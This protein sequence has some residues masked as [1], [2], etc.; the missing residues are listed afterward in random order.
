ML[1]RQTILS[2]VLFV[3]AA[4]S[5]PTRCDA[6]PGNPPALSFTATVFGATCERANGVLAVM[7][8]GG[9]A[10]YT[11]SL[12]GGPFQTDPVF[13]GLA[14]GSYTIA[15]SDAAGA[16]VTNSYTVANTFEPPTIAATHHDPTSCSLTD[17]TITPSGTGTA[18]PF[19]FSLDNINYQPNNN[20][21]NLAAGNYTVFIEDANGCTN[22]FHLTLNAA[23]VPD[24]SF[25]VSQ[26]DCSNYGD[27]TVVASNGVPAYQYSLDGTNFS[28]SGDFKTLSAGIYNAEVKDASGR[29]SIVATTLFANC[30]LSVSATATDANCGQNDGSITAR[31]ANGTLPY[32]YSIDFTHFQTDNSFTGLAP[33]NYLVTIKDGRGFVGTAA[34]TVGGLNTNNTLS[35][36]AG[37]DTTICQGASAR[38]SAVSNANAFS[39]TP[40]QSLSDSSAQ[41]PLATPGSTTKYYVSAGSGGCRV[42]DSVMVFVNPAPVADAGK[43]STICTGQDARLDG[44]GSVA[45]GGSGSGAGSGALTYSWTPAKFLSDPDIAQPIV[46]HPN[47]SLTY[48]LAVTDFL[49]CRSVNNASVRIALVP[50]AKVFA[51]TDTSVAIGQPLQLHASDVNNSGFDQYDWEPADLLNDPSVV[52]PIA[53]VG[54]STRFVV[55][56]STAGGCS[57][58]ASVLVRAYVGPDIYVPNAFTPNGDGH[59]DILRAIPIGMRSFHW[60]AVWGRNG[61][62]VFYTTNAGLGWDGMIGGKKAQTGAYIWMAAGID[63]KGSPLERKGTVMLVR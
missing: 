45:G 24:I 40:A 48:H 17:G 49:G 50:T 15:V 59:N 38:L 56:A 35:I 31:G 1:I 57:A 55:T 46:K 19:L 16:T 42:L 9:L 37:P 34:V 36:V 28:N 58:S 27:I 2:V 52:G 44:S 20:Y 47:I 54:V 4:V 61:Q 12:S 43:D 32:S 18:S 3:W 29:I 25:Q 21:I 26:P 62:Q 51:G 10:P 22:S 60:F 5:A 7:A 14:P 11:Y 13:N 41:D 23:C 63:Y 39:W 6:Q 30:P 8:T 33:G 53:T